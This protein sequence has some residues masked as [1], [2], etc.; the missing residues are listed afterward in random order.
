MPR[1]LLINM[2]FGEVRYPSIALGLF[3]ARFQEDGIPCDVAYLNIT[4]AEFVGLDNYDKVINMSSLM[5]GEQMFA[6]AMFGQYIPD[7]NEFFQE[8]VLPLVPME[9]VTRLQRMKSAVNPFLDHCMRKINWDNYDIIGFT[10]LFEQNTPS[11]AL[12]YQIKRRFPNK[13][14]VFG[15]ANMEEVMGLT[16]HKHFPFIDFICSGESDHT[17]PE[18]VK[19]IE[20]GSPVEDLAGIVY[21]DGKES[22]YTGKSATVRDLD[23]LPAPNY[24][25]F[26][27]QIRTSSLANQLDPYLLLESARGCWWGEKSHCTFCGLN[28]SSMV[29]RTK[30]SERC[31]REVV[32]LTRKYKVRYVRMVD[33]IINMS[34]FKDV[35]PQIAA[36]DLNARLMF[37]VKANLRKDQIKILSEANVEVQIGIESMSTHTLRLM[38]K[39]STGLMNVQTLKWCKQYGMTTD[40]NILYGFPGETADDYKQSLELARVLTHLDPPSGVGIIRMDRFSPNFDKSGE[41]GFTNVR[42]LKNYRFIYPFD[43]EILMDMIYFFEFDYKEDIQDGGY[44]QHFQHAVM[45]WKKSKD[46]LYMTLKNDQLHIFDSRPVVASQHIILRAAQWHIYEYCDQIRTVPQIKKWLDQH[47]DY[48]LDED[49]IEAILSEFIDQKLMI[50]EGT[51]FLSLAVMTYE[52]QP[53][54]TA[55]KLAALEH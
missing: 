30:S 31:F 22:V 43:Q 7:D 25:D 11:L 24:D 9:V 1:I 35:L 48:D 5:A 29:F 3:K 15:G 14:I 51:K 42:P 39:G 34:Y 37:E 41:M 21:R 2:P 55:R 53:D 44:L 54:L 17:F 36:I 12:A 23:A 20:N 46:Q 45:L 50:R 47:A 26:F 49:Q 4:F 13:T 28:G 10:S 38:G 8:I 32:A 52:A 18:L 33:N 16:I 6:K 27:Q 19:R 40:W